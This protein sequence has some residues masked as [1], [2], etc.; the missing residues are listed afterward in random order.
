LRWIS[1]QG[2]GSH[3]EA[4]QEAEPGLIRTPPTTAANTRFVLHRLLARFPCGTRPGPTISRLFPH[5]RTG[6]G[7]HT[8]RP[9][10]RA[11]PSRLTCRRH[12]LSAHTGGR[13]HVF[14]F[15]HCP[16][17]L[18]CRIGSALKRKPLTTPTEPPSA[19]NAPRHFAGSGGV[20]RLGPQSA[21][22]RLAGESRSPFTALGCGTATPARKRRLVCNRRGGI[23]RGPAYSKAIQT[24]QTRTW[25]DSE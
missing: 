20:Q 19:P 23:P 18:E 2:F 6:A 8:D 15:R 11:L 25:I 17:H 3:Q 1:T 10:R 12:P 9:E 21:P 5:S 22:S 14:G 13:R 24:I 4:G 16:M 7:V